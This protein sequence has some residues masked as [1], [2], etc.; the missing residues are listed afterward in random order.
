MMK[1]RIGLV[2][3]GGIAEKVYLP[4]MHEL[5]GAEW[6]GF[7]TRSAGKRELIEKK[8][9]LKSFEHLAD[10]LQEVD[11]VMIHAATEAHH[12]LAM[13]SL[14]AGKHVYIDKP[15]AET[16]EQAEELVR[17]ARERKLLLTVGFNRRFAPFYR[18]I[19]ELPLDSVASIR[20]EKHRASRVK[21]VPASETL[22]DDYIHLVDT[23]HW[24]SAGR[25]IRLLN[26]IIQT[27]DAGSLVYAE[28]SF[29]IDERIPAHISMH[30]SCGSNDERLSAVTVNGL[31]DVR[32]LSQST[33]TKDAA[34]VRTAPSWE[35]ILRT[36]GFTDVVH[37]FI[38]AIREGNPLA[39]TGEDGV[40]SGRLLDRIISQSTYI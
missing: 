18:E 20:M 22:F 27:D 24:L 19:A 11:A 10:L 30:R 39:V 1:V 23:I 29:L 5:T 6:I 4:L 13:E 38:E 2:G 8:S 14:L 21:P 9:G 16:T 26:G 33:W 40:E 7:H 37:Q 35:T 25:P 17:I 36:K 34:F 15:L 28:H 31:Y 32:N 12:S 3:I